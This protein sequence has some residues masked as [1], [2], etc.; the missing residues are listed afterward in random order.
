MA[1]DRR[2]RAALYAAF[3]ILF[4]TGAA[5]LVVDAQQ[6]N[7]GAW[8]ETSTILLMTHGGAAMAMLM[9]LGA[10]FT[11]HILPSWR[12]GRNRA[13]GAVVLILNTLLILTAFGLYYLGSETLR[14]W[15]SDMHIVLGFSLPALL[16]LHVVF[17]KRASARGRRAQSADAD[18]T[19]LDP[20]A[21]FRSRAA[22]DR[23]PQDPTATRARR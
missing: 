23:W 18:G 19:G 14:R 16:L 11:L 22:R 2:F 6:A 13:S 21:T 15:T 9:L 17:G 20:A 5:W 7:P 8:P 10:I 1:L 3:A 12:L 4:A